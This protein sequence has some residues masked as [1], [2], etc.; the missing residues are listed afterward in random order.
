MRGVP[1]MIYGTAWKKERTATLV[2]EA[3]FAGYRGIDTACQPKHYDEAGV[4]EGIAACGIARETLYLQTKFTPLSGQDPH[5]IPYD[6]HAPLALQVAQ[7][8]EVSLRNLRTIYIDAWILHSPLSTFADTLTVWNAMQKGVEE[9]KVMSLG[10]SNCYDLGILRR[11]YDAATVKPTILQNRFYAD[12][13]YDREI[14]AWCNEHGIIYESFWSLTA[15]PFLVASDTVRSIAIVHVTTPVLV[16]YAFLR[17]LKIVPL[18]GTTSREHMLE[19]LDF[20]AIQL[21]E[22]E[23]AKLTMLLE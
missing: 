6:P 4:G 2:K 17:A 21:D 20:V 8:L 9:R 12:T 14:R 23:M 13:H 18:N 1:P 16:W 15:N 10:I 3:I 11:L 7:S 22:A 19:D 5:A